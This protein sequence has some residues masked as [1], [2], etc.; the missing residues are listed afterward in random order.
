MADI[1][2]DLQECSWRGIS[3]PIQ[4]IA[5]KGAQN[6]AIHTKMDRNGAQVE[7]TGR[8]PY[9]FSIK[10]YLI[11][12]LANGPQETWTNLFPNTWNSLRAAL[13]DNHSTGS[14]IHP[15]YGIIKCKTVSW[16]N[17][18]NS[19][20]RNGMIVTINF[21]ETI[22]NDELVTPNPTASAQSAAINLDAYLG[23]LDPP[24]PLDLGGFDSL[25]DLV[26]SI[27][28]VVDQV[29]LAS[30]KVQ[31]KINRAIKTVNT[32]NDINAQVVKI[33]TDA[34]KS[35]GNNIATI[36]DAKD[37]FLDSFYQLGQVQGVI[38]KDI[39]FYDVPQNTT[40]G[41]IASTLGNKVSDLLR[42]NPVTA[43]KLIIVRGTK[44]K[45]YQI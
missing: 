37:Q 26:N 39:A 9:S 44:I 1:F 12:G 34:T 36:L 6:L 7:G 11:N 3:F 33:G 28:S 10:A 30:Q 45:Y 8:A 19:D 22:D 17:E 16:E 4:S 27:T 42:L 41:S 2:T 40:I 13:G 23:L 24:L 32:I 29:E 25:T 38:N 18:I 31:A 14:L 5:E 35:L 43:G 21:T 15:L 20:L